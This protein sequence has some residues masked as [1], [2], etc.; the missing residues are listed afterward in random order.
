M[1]DG[2]AFEGMMAVPA[3]GGDSS[4]PQS[5]LPPGVGGAAEAAA[6]GGLSSATGGGGGSSSSA[7]GG[8]APASVAA[9]TATATATPTPFTGG[10]NIT[11]TGVTPEMVDQLERNA[12]QLSRN[13]TNMMGMLGSSVAAAT[14]ITSEH[15]RAE[16]MAVDN[17][18]LG[19]EQCMEK[20][21]NLITQCTNVN[22]AMGPLTVL[23]RQLAQIKKVLDETESYFKIQPL[24]ST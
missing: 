5:T 19:S 6:E 2:A 21:S 8:T 3:T 17:I 4:G 12:V 18:T 14:Q 20:L 1:N 24:K 7:Q 22:N 16:Q 15:M 13:L 11:R 9:P 23:A 10:I